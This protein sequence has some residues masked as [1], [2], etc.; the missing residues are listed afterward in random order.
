MRYLRMQDILEI[1]GVSRTTIDRWEAEGRFPRR[2]KLGGRAIGWLESEV[3][4]WVNTRAE[5]A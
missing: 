1:T 2:R 5:A 4:E 3:L